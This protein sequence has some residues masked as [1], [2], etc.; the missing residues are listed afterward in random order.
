MYKSVI[1]SIFSCTRVIMVAKQNVDELGQFDRYGREA[2]KFI[3]GN[4]PTVA[5]TPSK[6]ELIQWIREPLLSNSRAPFEARV[7]GQQLEIKRRL[8]QGGWTW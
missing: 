8:M 1:R 5:A 2:T 6:T 7:R 3:K 4:K